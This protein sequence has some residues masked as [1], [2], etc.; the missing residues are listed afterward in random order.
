MGFFKH[1]GREAKLKST[2]SSWLER[3]N[4]Y[5]KVP[6]EEFRQQRKMY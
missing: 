5:V 6:A 1:M 3:E 2:V 4:F